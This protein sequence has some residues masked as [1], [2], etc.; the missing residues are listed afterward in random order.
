MKRAMKLILPLAVAGLVAMA[1][2]HLR[3]LGECSC[4]APLIVFGSLFGCGGPSDTA[5][6][7]PAAI[8]EAP[9]P[10]DPDIDGANR[11]A[12]AAIKKYTGPVKVTFVEIGSVNCVPCRMMQPVMDKIEQNFPGQVKIVFHDVWTPEGR[13][14]GMKY[15]IRAIPTQVFLDKNEKEYFRHEGF[16]PYEEV[17]KV[18]KQQ[19]VE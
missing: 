9:A 14:H 10:T 13:P 12:Y 4:Q 7:A 5:A 19:G 11:G 16:L 2:T 6:P 8:Q 15:G 18:L 3:S 17:V 1:G